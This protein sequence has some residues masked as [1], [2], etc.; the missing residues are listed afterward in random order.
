MIQRTRQEQEELINEYHASNKPAR[1][2]CRERGIAYSTF[3]R[4]LR[5]TKTK[6]PETTVIGAPA[7]ASEPKAPHPKLEIVE[8][9]PEQRVAWAVVNANGNEPARIQAQSRISLKRRDWEVSVGNGFDPELLTE[10]P[11]VVDRVCC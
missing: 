5:R 8:S 3:M 10:V 4:W 1:T 11:K 2:W 9:K 7:S 6:R